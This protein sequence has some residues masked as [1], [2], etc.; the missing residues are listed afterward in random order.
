MSLDELKTLLG[1]PL[2]DNSEDARLLILLDAAMDF[3]RAY[4]GTTYETFKNE[5]TGDYLL[6]SLVKVG[7]SKLVEA[8]DRDPAVTSES[9]GGMSQ[10]FGGPSTDAI[11]LA[12]FKPYG[13]KFGFIAARSPFQPDVEILDVRESQEMLKLGT[14]P[15]DGR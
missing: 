8:A 10:S 6:P 3:V 14:D 5:T 13:R 12:Y 1:I 15:E 7:I 11:A 2:T 4:L 9:I